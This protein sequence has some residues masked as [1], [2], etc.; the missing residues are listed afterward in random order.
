MMT[1]QDTQPGLNNLGI[2]APGL[3]EAKVFNLQLMKT[4]I[5]LSVTFTSEQRSLYLIRTEIT[6]P[7]VGPVSTGMMMRMLVGEGPQQ[8]DHHWETLGD[9]QWRI[10]PQYLVYGTPLMIFDLAAENAQTLTLV[11]TT[12]PV[13]S[14]EYVW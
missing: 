3:P 9:M 13:E 11:R 10:V 6:W 14:V 1:E 2:E 8:D 12:S 7:G 5:P 4:G